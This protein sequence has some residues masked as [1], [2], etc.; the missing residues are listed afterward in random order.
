MAD[1]VTPPISRAYDTVAQTY[2][3]DLSPNAW[4]RE[5]L[6]AKYLQYFR[7]G[8]HILDIACGTGIDTLH[9]TR[10][11]MTVTGLDR[12]PGMLAQLTQKATATPTQTLPNTLIAD[13]SRLP[14][15][16]QPCFDGAISSFA[17]LNTTAD[18]TRFA[19]EISA[20]LKPGSH[21]FIHLLNR[22]CVWEWLALIGRGNWQEA[23]TYRS[24]HAFTV[25]IGG[26]NV[27]HYFYS[28]RETYKRYFA[29][30]FELCHHYGLAALR[31]PP[32][33]R[34]FPAP[35]VRQLERWEKRVNALP[36]FRDWGNF[37]LLDMVKR[38]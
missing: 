14:F 26:V 25:S 9:L 27:P 2:D 10:H 4:M 38:P 17:G 28:P 22:F 7:P 18:L 34:L 21:L 5:F 30:D 36:P 15:P 23:R 29:E 20:R 19:R 24:R 33:L 31:P 32:H 37:F 12:A 35:L 11:G 1:P 16:R 3:A 6:W 13:F 8:D